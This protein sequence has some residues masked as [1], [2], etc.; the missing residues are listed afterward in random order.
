MP[1]SSM[2]RNEPSVVENE[3]SSGTVRA[4]V[5][6]AATLPR[7]WDA[8][9]RRESVS[10]WFGDLSRDITPNQSIRLDFGDGDFF[11]IEG[12][13]AGAPTKLEF[14]WRFLGTGPSDNIKWDIEDQGEKCR[15]TV[16]DYEPARS[17]KGC[18][19]LAE[20]WTDFLERL[21]KYLRTNE[22]ARYDWRRDFDGSIE[23][24]VSASEAASLLS[25]HR[26]RFLWSP[27]ET[28]LKGGAVHISAI[29][30]KGPGC[31]Q[32]QLQAANWKRPTECRL[33]IVPRSQTTSAVVIRHT[34]WADISDDPVFCMTERRRFSDQWI[35]AL[36]ETRVL[37]TIH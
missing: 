27:W 22:L 18:L 7:V 28:R 17:Q 37:V 26:G 23:L 4:S 31:V 36:K 1:T 9:T 25:A 14:R 3:I 19:E 5:V 16:T 33:E 29:D 6:V 12:A 8:I 32:F 20:G 35:A 30:W 2:T 24:S 13:R 34:G 21:E 15:V 10:M 11:V